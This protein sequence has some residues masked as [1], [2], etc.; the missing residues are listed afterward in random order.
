[1]PAP[2]KP[3]VEEPNPA[4][5]PEP[6]PTETGEQ[7]YKVVGPHEVLGNAPGS[8]FTAE[9]PAVQLRLLLEAGH[10]IHL[11]EQ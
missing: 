9:I 4:L 11:K 6:E 5:V 7:A 3:A 1:M 10:I 8:E 2:K